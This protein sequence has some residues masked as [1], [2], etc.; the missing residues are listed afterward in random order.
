MSLS[1]SVLLVTHNARD[2]IAT[3]VKGAFMELAR[4]TADFEI[5]VIDNGSQD[6]TQDVLRRLERHVSQVTIVHYSHDPSPKLAIV[7]GLEKTTKDFV[8]CADADGQYDIHDLPRFVQ[9]LRPDTDLING[10]RLEHVR[11]PYPVWLGE[12]YRRSIQWVFG[13]PLSDVQCNFRLFRRSALNT[14][15]L[16]ELSSDFFWIDMI[17][18][19][20]S[21]GFNMIETPATYL[22]KRFVPHPLIDVLESLRDVARLC[23]LRCSG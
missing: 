1:I 14:V 15:S 23:R 8:L 12:L 20:H 3:I 16:R 21:W 11:P 22:P 6:G 5:V 13:L 2:I 10:Y 18:R 4:I 17:R 9:Q 7:Q 19:M